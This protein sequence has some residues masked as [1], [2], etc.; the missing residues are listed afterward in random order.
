MECPFLPTEGGKY[1]HKHLAFNFDWLRH[2][3]MGVLMF[4]R[5]LNLPLG[6]ILDTL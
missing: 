5:R 1:D 6:G 3:S 2:L 4:I